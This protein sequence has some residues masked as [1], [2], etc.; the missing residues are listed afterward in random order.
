MTFLSSLIFFPFGYPWSLI[1]LE[2]KEHRQTL[3]FFY[4]VVSHI[5]LAEGTENTLN[6]LWLFGSGISAIN[7]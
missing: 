3:V 7:A 1:F 4:F 5:Y 6:M 2:I